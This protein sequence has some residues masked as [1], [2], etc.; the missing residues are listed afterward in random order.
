MWRTADII[1]W[2][3]LGDNVSG[4]TRPTYRSSVKTKRSGTSVS[5]ITTLVLTL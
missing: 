2:F 1:F 4:A 5:K 3:V